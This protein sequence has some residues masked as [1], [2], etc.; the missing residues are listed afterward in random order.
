M[1]GMGL[2][3]AKIKNQAATYSPGARRPQYHQRWE[4]FY[5]ARLTAL[6]AKPHGHRLTLHRR[7]LSSLK[8]ALCRLFSLHVSHCHKIGVT[9][10]RSTSYQE[11]TSNAEH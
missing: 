9:E 11:N 7:T 2:S 3:E 5:A 4:L 6:S 8:I 1:A 10:C